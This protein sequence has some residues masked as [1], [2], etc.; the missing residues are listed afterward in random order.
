MKW[1][2]VVLVCWPMLAGAQP[3]TPPSLGASEENISKSAQLTELQK[4]VKA[5]DRSAPAGFW[6][7]LAAKGGPLIDP[8]AD[9]PHHLL[10]T[11]LYRDEKAKNVVV[12]GLSGS[13]IPD[14]L[15]RL[16]GTDLWARS[17]RI[18]DD[19]RV[20]YWFAVDFPLEAASSSNLDFSKIARLFR[21]DSLNLHRIG[22]FQSLL[23]LPKAGAQPLTLPGRDAAAGEVHAHKITSRMLGNERSVYV[24]TPPGYRADGGPYPLLVLFDGSDYLSSIPGATIL[25]NLIAQKR[26]P[27]TIAV[28]IDPVDRLHELGI[29]EKFIDV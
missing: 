3:R 27:A 20:A 16:Q 8:L 22:P 23:T 2:I 5:G 10:V 14:P 11:F 28:M 6:K 15:T 9:S 19:A 4:K 24:Y 1:S 17:Y 21:P 13:P 12:L 29:G 25:D 26:L 18:V 7:S